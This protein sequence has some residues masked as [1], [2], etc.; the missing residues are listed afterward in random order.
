M[1]EDDSDT[2]ETESVIDQMDTLEME[3]VSDK[4]GDN[5]PGPLEVRIL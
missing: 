1:F 2:E 5:K 3:R 4:D